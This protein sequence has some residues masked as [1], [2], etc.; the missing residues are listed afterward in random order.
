MNVSNTTNGTVT[1]ANETLI[2]AATVSHR[3]VV[4]GVLL[5]LVVLVG[6]PGNMV[7]LR[8]TANVCR[9]SRQN[10]Y[11]F[12][13][14]C[15]SDT[16]LL[17][18][19]TPCLVYMAFQETHVNQV[20]VCEVWTVTNA[21]IVISVLTNSIVAYERHEI[22]VCFQRYLVFFT[23]KKILV[24]KVLIWL[25]TLMLIIIVLKSLMFTALMHE[26]GKACILMSTFL[27]LHPKTSTYI[28]SAVVIAI[29][30]VPLAVIVY[31]YSFIIMAI[32]KTDLLKLDHYDEKQTYSRIVRVSFTRV[33]LSIT[34]WPPFFVVL[35][36]GPLLPDVYLKY[37]R[38]LDYLT[39][40]Q[41]VFSPYITLQDTDFNGKTRKCLEKCGSLKLNQCRGGTGN[42]LT[43]RQVV[44]HKAYISSAN[45]QT[46][47]A[48][49]LD[50][51]HLTNYL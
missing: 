36:L 31:S 30:L 48:S 26:E 6:L 51:S 23:P 38:F 10:A 12:F 17:L 8:R 42:G 33:L 40:A 4:E 21:F 45:Q 25:M 14:L 3:H 20:A 41:A 2:H 7:L 39:V 50:D 34:T 32:F 1:N 47:V 13:G 5:S 27:R 11:L 44:R 24:V 18:A 46:M 16:F 22:M 15:L 29:I 37:I 43:R 19:R 49:E 28:L 35:A 9:Q